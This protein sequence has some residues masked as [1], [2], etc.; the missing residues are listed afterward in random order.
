MENIKTFCMHT[1]IFVGMQ[2]FLYAYKKG[3]YAYKKYLF[4]LI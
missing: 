2:K 3:L 1:E 4:D